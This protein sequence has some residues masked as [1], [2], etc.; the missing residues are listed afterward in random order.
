MCRCPFN[1][2]RDTYIYGTPSKVGGVNLALSK[3]DTQNMT[4][5]CQ[6]DVFYHLI[7]K[8]NSRPALINTYGQGPTGREIV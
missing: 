8:S 1:W 6:V 4:P 7:L 2:E 5:Y 3:Y